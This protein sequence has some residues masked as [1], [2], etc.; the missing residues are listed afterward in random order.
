MK[1]MTVYRVAVMTQKRKNVPSLKNHVGII[2]ITYGLMMF[3]A[4][5]VGSLKMAKP[6]SEKIKRYEVKKAI[7]R[8]SYRDLILVNQ[9]MCLS[10]PV[11][12]L[13]AELAECKRKNERFE[14][15]NHV[16]VRIVIWERI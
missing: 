1:T 4:G 7:I 10:E 16:I 15:C 3:V 9:K 12:R 14:R 13:E 5:V 8:D 2:V 6:M 11:A